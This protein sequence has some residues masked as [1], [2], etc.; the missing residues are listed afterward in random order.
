MLQQQKLITR[1]VVTSAGGEIELLAQII[2]RQSFVKVHMIAYNIHRY[3]E[4]E[5]TTWLQGA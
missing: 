3:R 5:N 4:Q 1:R 2:D